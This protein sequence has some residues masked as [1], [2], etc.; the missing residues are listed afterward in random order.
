MIGI[1]AGISCAAPLSAPLAA[2]GQGHGHGCNACAV[3]TW[4]GSNPFYGKEKK[5]VTEEHFTKNYGDLAGGGAYDVVRQEPGRFAVGLQAE[6]YYQTD[7]WNGP[8][9]WN[10]ALYFD[11]DRLSFGGYAGDVHVAGKTLKLERG[12][13][14]SGTRW[15]APAVQGLPGQT[16]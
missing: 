10:D 4:N 3:Q 1:L 15:T 13:S 2:V 11:K 6:K 16:R 8:V 7:Q 5:G 12:L 14:V 9:S